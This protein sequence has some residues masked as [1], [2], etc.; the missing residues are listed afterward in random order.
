[1]PDSNINDRL[2]CHDTVMIDYT[3]RLHCHNPVFQNESV[4]GVSRIALSIKQ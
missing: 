3:N 2:H 4:L 1:M